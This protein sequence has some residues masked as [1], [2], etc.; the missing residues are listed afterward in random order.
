VADAVSYART[1]DIDIDVPRLR[2]GRRDLVLIPGTLSHAE[3][4]WVRDLVA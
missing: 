3:L 1:D 4:C 2:R